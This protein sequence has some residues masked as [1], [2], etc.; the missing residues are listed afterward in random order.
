MKNNIR[1]QYRIY[2]N[3]LGI[4]VISYKLIANKATKQICLCVCNNETINF[5]LQI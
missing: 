3:I 5:F 1:I 2:I 4:C